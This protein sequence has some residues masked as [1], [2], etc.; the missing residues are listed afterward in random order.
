MATEA[1]TTARLKTRY[2]EEIRVGATTGSDGK[3]ARVAK[4][5][6]TQID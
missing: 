5:S 2:L 6:D 1:P 4:R 3:K